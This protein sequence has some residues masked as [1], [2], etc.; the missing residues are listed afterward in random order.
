MKYKRFWNKQEYPRKCPKC[1]KIL[2][3]ERQ[4]DLHYKRHHLK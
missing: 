2:N 1:P 4:E 3:S